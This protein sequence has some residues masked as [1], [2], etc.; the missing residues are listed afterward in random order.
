MN[1]IIDFINGFSSVRDFFMHGYCYWFAVILVNRFPSGV[2]YYLPIQN[3]FVVLVDERWYDASGFAT[4]TE[5]PMMWDLYK[6]FDEL[7]ASRIE[8][9]CIRKEI[10]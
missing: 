9:D 8:R 1:E 7:E 6:Q 3:H 10:T 2:I 4:V 5:I